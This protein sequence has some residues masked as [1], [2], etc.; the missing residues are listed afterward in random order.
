MWS[1]KQFVDVG[2]KKKLVDDNVKKNV[3]FKKMRD[4]ISAWKYHQDGTMKYV[5][6]TQSDKGQGVQQESASNMPGRAS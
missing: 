5:P 4:I 2:L 6:K 1:G 3:V